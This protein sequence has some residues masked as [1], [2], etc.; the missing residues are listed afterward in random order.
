MFSIGR[1]G[2][3][4]TEVTWAPDPSGFEKGG[5]GDAPVC[6]E[7]G[8]G[9]LVSEN[10]YPGQREEW[11]PHSGRLPSALPSSNPWE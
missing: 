4:P 7:G 1:F 11:G 6:L 2:I 3:S 9:D 10:T 8:A 5:E